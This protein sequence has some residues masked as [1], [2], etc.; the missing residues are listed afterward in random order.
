LL[1]QDVAATTKAGSRSK[2]LIHPVKFRQIPQIPLVLGLTACRPPAIGLNK[3]LATLS[4]T[5][6]TTECASS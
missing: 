3:G 4:N 2:R 6:V 5:R 1:Q